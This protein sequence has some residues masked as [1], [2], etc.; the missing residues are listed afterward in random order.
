MSTRRKFSALDN[1]YTF[2][3][4]AMLIAAWVVMMFRGNWYAGMGVSEQQDGSGIALALMFGL[5]FV[6]VI[7]VTKP[8]E[9]VV[10]KCFPEPQEPVHD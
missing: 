5:A 8:I 10:K 2:R 1:F 9:L 6:G 3:T 7:I 4:V